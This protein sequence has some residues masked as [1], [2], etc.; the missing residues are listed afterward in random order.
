MEVLMLAAPLILAALLVALF[1]VPALQRRSTPH[2][3]QQRRMK[4][5]RA[6]YQRSLGAD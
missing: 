2:A 5:A 1:V 6:E 3:K 4:Q